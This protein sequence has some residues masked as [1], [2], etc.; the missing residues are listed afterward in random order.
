MIPTIISC[1]LTKINLT[2]FEI[3]TN[4][5]SFKLQTIWLLSYVKTPNNLLKAP[6]MGTVELRK[7]AV[8]LK[9]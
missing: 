6:I 4:I 8:A 5:L 2:R 1:G 9:T 7:A 3:F